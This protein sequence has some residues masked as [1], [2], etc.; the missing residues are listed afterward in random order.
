MQ[1]TLGV[2]TNEVYHPNT[3]DT[4]TVQL[5]CI[6]Q[7]D[8]GC[9]Q[10]CCFICSQFSADKELFNMTLAADI[11]LGPDKLKRINAITNNLMN[12]SLDTI[13]DMS[14]MPPPQGSSHAAS[15]ALHRP[16]DDGSVSQGL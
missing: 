4:L 11:N 8:I 6:R 16:P 10:C 14:A 3:Q 9:Q 12:F 15:R 1:H 13:M 7:D 5:Q 2:D